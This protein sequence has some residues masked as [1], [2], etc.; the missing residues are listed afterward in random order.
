MEKQV[1][2]Q[3]VLLGVEEQ[4]N[5]SS[6]YS[7]YPN[8][9][10]TFIEPKLEYGLYGVK[11]FS[12]NKIDEI[13]YA[14]NELWKLFIKA[15]NYIKQMDSGQLTELGYPKELHEFLKFDYL[16]H[17]TALSRF[18]FVVSEDG[19]I[20][21]LEI[22]N[23]TPFLVQEAFQ[24]NKEMCAEFGVKDANKDCYDDLFKSY[25]QAIMDCSVYLGVTKPNVVIIGY[26][27]DTDYEEFCTV[28]YIR[29]QI[30]QVFNVEFEEINKIRVVSETDNEFYKRGLYTSEMKR[31]DILIKP[32]YP[33]EFLID[34]VA[35]DGE[36]IGIELL[37]M[38]EEKRLALINPPSSTIKQSKIVMAIVWDWY[39]KGIIL[40]DHLR[41]IVEKYMLP[42]YLNEEPFSHTAY[43]KK[44]IYSREGSSVEIIREG[45]SVKS[46]YNMYDD[47]Q[48]IYQEYIEL[49]KQDVVVNGEKVTK[50]YIVGSFVT[51]DK[52]SALALRLG[53]DITEWNSH[54]LALGVTE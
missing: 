53:G 9:F 36:K 7:K 54:W 51:C 43:V 50:S 49:P 16:T 44:P 29:S 32:A 20:K 52:A 35:E 5:R 31:I 17:H 2:A 28:D 39:E 25:L 45:D 11:L 46:Q 6:F 15:K 40:S 14:T 24:M 23:D 3:E 13:R 21:M 41:G 48:H 18:D 4:A 33:Y 1:L 26:D 38:V 30:P 10:S 47:F 34:D 42:T 27:I 12:K 22:N 19:R 37:K 8:F